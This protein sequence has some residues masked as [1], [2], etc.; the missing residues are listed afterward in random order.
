MSRENEKFVIASE[1]ILDHYQLGSAQEADRSH[2]CMDGDFLDGRIKYYYSFFEDIM[3]T[4]GFATIL[5][6]II[7][8]FGLLGMATYS[9]R[10]KKRINGTASGAPMEPEL[11]PATLP[12]FHGGTPIIAGK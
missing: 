12:R 6:L 4:V 7:A 8:S 3:Y 2:P 9:T 5:A 10:K 1:M 11:I